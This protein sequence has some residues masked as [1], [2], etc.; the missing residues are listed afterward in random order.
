MGGWNS[1]RMDDDS[2]V[3][4][5]FVYLEC[6]IARVFVKAG[7]TPGKVKLEWK[8][9]NGMSGEVALETIAAPGRDGFLDS[10]QQELPANAMTF[11]RKTDAV[12]FQDLAG[13]AASAVKYAVYVN[14][15]KV[16]FPHGLGAPVKPDD[17][18]GVCCAYVP[19]LEAIKAAGAD[20]EFTVDPKKIPSNKKWLRK[21]SASVYSP[22]LTVKAGGREIDACIGFTELFLDNGKDKNLTNCEIYRARDKSPIICGELVALVGYIP[23]VEVATDG[24]KQRVDITVRPG[25]E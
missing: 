4:K 2:P 16:S 14:G 6:G 18:T 12:A 13:L 25:K 8:C 24:K 21:L 7:R 17:N 23:G 22:T 15:K 20:V 11:E 9:D 19:V 3:G 5:D 1:G 10:P